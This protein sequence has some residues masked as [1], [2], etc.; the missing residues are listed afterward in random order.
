MKRIILAAITI[1]LSAGLCGA[2]AILDRNHLNGVRS[3]LHRPTYVAAYDALLRNADSLLDVK[4][5]SVMD[6]ERNS[7]SGDNHDYTSLARYFHPDTTKAD[8]LPYVNR[9]GISNPEL[10]L[11]D[12][13]RLG[14]TANRVRDLALAWY[15]S[16]DERYAAK[17]AELLNV[18]F[19]D[20]STRMNPH[21][22][23]A[24]MVPGVNNK[25][26]CYGV[27]DGYSFI[28]MLDGVALLEGSASWTDSDNERLKS[29]MS[30]LLD[31]ILTS[32]QGVE[33]A[34]AANNHSTAYDA[35]AI[36]LAIYTG[37]HD[38]ARSI[39]EAFP[40]HRLFAQIAPDGSQPHEMDRTLSF[41]YSHY[42]LTHFIDIMLMARKMGMNLDTL[43]DSEGRSFYRAV[44]YM[45]S[46]LGREQSEWPGPQIQDWQP[47]QQA[48]AK[49]LWRVASALD[50]TRADYREL[51]KRYGTANPADRF[52]LLYYA[53]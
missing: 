37:R 45:A 3:Q 31:W 9:D 1:F 6:K 13:N 23:Y 27:L 7:P 21:F 30:S 42:N 40:S 49:D 29:W 39:L 12:R 46:Y 19:L 53:D 52:I 28:D 33:E 14:T 48:L 16:R 11:Y 25:G 20:P 51:Y 35:Q 15:F 10:A 41:H 43:T 18:W 34:N 47:A 22:E 32:P 4:P 26:R 5:Y 44:D 38:I 8:G 2:Q 17:A 24:Q 36:A 50:A